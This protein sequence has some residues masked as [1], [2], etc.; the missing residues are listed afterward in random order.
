ME[1]EDR[2]ELNILEERS[3]RLDKESVTMRNFYGVKVDIILRASKMVKHSALYN[4]GEGEV[5]LVGK[6][7]NRHYTYVNTLLLKNKLIIFK[8]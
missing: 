7:V 6:C 1:I 4:E 8:H 2:C 3:C 5:C